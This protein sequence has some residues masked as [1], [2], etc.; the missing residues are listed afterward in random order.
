MSWYNT[1]FSA[2]P[3]SEFLCSVTKRYKR[4]RSLEARAR[5]TDAKEAGHEGP[6]SR[7][8]AAL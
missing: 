8:Q 4:L 2:A 7:S 6:G 1:P 3:R 5:R